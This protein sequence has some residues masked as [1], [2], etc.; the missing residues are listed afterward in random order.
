ML[1]RI[2]DGRLPDGSR[3]FSDRTARELTTLVTPIPIVDPPPELAALR[4]N[5]R[6]YALGLDVHDYRG[7]KVITHTGGLPGYV[8][9]VT[10]IPDLKLGVAVLTNQE[11]GAA[12]SALTWR[13]VD[14]YLNALNA[15]NTPNASNAN[16]APTDW[17]DAYAKLVARRTAETA[18]TE[19][20]AAA[21]RDASSKPSLPLE[22]YA[23]TYTDA[24]YGDV[25]IAHDNGKLVMRFTHTPSL[26]GDLEH[27]QHDT[28]I[29]RWRDRE[30]RAD[31]YVIFA[32]DADGS[33]DQIKMRAVSP[34]TDF[35]FDFQDLLLRPSRAARR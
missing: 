25:E 17:V 12:F 27:W 19:K 18:A 15:P 5:F 23:G 34:S 9:K 8:S 24:W 10:V 32:L 29:V 20:R 30:L 16:A 21:A 35:S 1:V 6:G 31:A 14:Q 13:V 4:S 22:R 26:I 3:L 28:F 7:H 33:I 2:A 11:S